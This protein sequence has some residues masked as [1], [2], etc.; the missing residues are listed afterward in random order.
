MLQVNGG[1]IDMEMSSTMFHN[2]TQYEIL[3]NLQNET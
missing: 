1:I 3:I 2:W